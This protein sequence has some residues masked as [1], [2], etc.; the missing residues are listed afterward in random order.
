MINVHRIDDPGIRIVDGIEGVQCTLWT[1]EP[2]APDPV[3]PEETGILYEL[4]HAVR[5]E[6]GELIV[7]NL[8][9]I[10]V[11]E[12]DGS[13]EGTYSPGEDRLQI[14]P[15]QQV[16]ILG[17]VKLYLVPDSPG[18]L[19][20]EDSE[21]ILEF[22]GRATLELGFRSLHNTPAGTII[23][24]EEPESLMTA[25]SAF[26]S[27]LQMT[28]CERSYPN[29][30]GHPPALEFGDH[31]SIPDQIQPPETG[32]TIE[33]PPELEYIFPAAPLAYY[34]GAELVPGPEPVLDYGTGRYSLNGA[35]E[36]E[37]ATIETLRA[38]H[39][40][41]CIVRTEGYFQLDLAVEK[42]F[43]NVVGEEFDPAELYDQ[44]LTEQ[45][46]TYL[47]MVTSVDG[48]ETLLPDWSVCVDIVPEI[49]HARAL[50]YLVDELAL[51]RMKAHGDRPDPNTEVVE[52]MDDFLRSGEATVDLDDIFYLEDAPAMTQAYLGE[53]VAVKATNLSVD[54]LERRVDR[55]ERSDSR[56]SVAVICNDPMMEEES[57]VETYYGIRDLIHFDV[58][59]Y[60]EVT[61]E[62]LADL[63]TSD[64]DL[65]HY[66]GHVDDDGIQCADGPLDVNSL[67]EITADAVLL[68]GCA[69]YEQGKALIDAGALASVVTVTPISNSLATKVGRAIARTLNCGFPVNAALDVVSKHTPTVQYSI[70]GDGNL[71][72]VQSE[73][74]V[75]YY[76]EA[77]PASKTSGEFDAFLVDIFG[78]PVSNHGPGSVTHPHLGGTTNNLVFGQL[79]QVLVDV[80]EFAW[81]CEKTFYP[82]S[83]NRALYWTDELSNADLDELLDGS[84][85]RSTGGRSTTAFQRRHSLVQHQQ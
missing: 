41:D 63:L 26:S 15:G 1:D 14:D 61:R 65:I 23:C 69:S 7:P 18:L 43:Y 47:D 28:S 45:L 32:V 35:R 81:F 51:I 71:Q 68:N 82:V 49:E 42:E 22:D 79:K 33:I 16:D 72:L 6:T 5:I 38:V 12:A 36:Y 37:D 56:I 66:I 20:T 50:P 25:I 13:Y 46:E 53:H 44:S 11:R 24:P 10:H 85:L 29:H 31:L 48:F 76:L 70:V 21:V 74:G 73:S 80:D 78:Y 75:P 62:R 17:A 67:P 30:Q 60:H 39:F 52:T 59:G 77:E 64:Y 40:L 3:D 8:E 4:D 54:V 57:V 34:L 2:V 9:T 84:D 83:I 55:P 58:E 19:Y 27:S